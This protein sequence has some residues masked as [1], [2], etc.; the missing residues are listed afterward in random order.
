MGGSILLLFWRSAAT[1]IVEAN[2]I[3]FVNK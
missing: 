1:S 3:R 2:L